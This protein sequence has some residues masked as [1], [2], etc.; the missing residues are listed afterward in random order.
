MDF[1]CIFYYGY[2]NKFLIGPNIEVLCIPFVPT[3]LTVGSSVA[4]G[5]FSVALGAFSV[6]MGAFPSTLLSLVS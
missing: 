1:D 4:V 2:N 6:A 3:A 5:A